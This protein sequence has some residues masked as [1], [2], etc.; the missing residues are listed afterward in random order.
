MLEPR[1][2][3]EGEGEGRERER[4]FVAIDSSS[5][6]AAVIQPVFRPDSTP[7][8]AASQDS[9][10]KRNVIRMTRTASFVVREDA[11]R[12]PMEFSTPTHDEDVT[13]KPK[14]CDAVDREMRER[15]R[16]FIPR[17]KMKT[18]SCLPRWNLV[19]RI[20]ARLTISS[21]SDIVCLAL[22]S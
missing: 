4:Y 14:V 15:P 16:V 17:M 19:L 1:K 3:R 12:N 5:F 22:A 6:V 20:D 21:T 7:R 10:C 11:A 13:R 2:E 9:K 18:R 8:R